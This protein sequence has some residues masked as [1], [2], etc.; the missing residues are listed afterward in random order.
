MKKDSELLRTNNNLTEF[1]LYKSSNGEVKIDVL[2]QNENIWMPQ[3]NIAKLF[4]VNV[5]AISKHLNNIFTERELNE[6]S[7]VSILEITDDEEIIKT[8]F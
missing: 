6:N 1:L 2:L 8:V 7:V 4:D 3:K 5:P